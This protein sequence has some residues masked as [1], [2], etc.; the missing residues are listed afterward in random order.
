MSVSATGK[1]VAVIGGGPA[2][3]IAAETLA[4]AGASV[5]LYDRMPS[6]GRKFLM[7]GR[8]GLNLTHSEPLETFVRR[9]GTAAP[10]LSPLIEHFSPAGLTQWCEALGQ[11]TF[12]GSSGRVFPKSMKASPLLRAWLRRLATL[13]VTVETRT[14]WRGWSANGA[15]TFQRDTGEIF[16]V[17]P[18]ATI[19]A[20]GGASWPRLGADGGWVETLRATGVDVAPLVASNAGVAVAW[21]DHIRARFAGAP[22]KRIAITIDGATQRGEAVITAA[23]LEGGAIYALSPAIRA[24]LARGPAQISIDLRPDLTADVLAAR[25]ARPRGK[26]TLT[27]HLRKTLAL[28]PAAIAL[29]RDDTRGA[30][31]K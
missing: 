18:D 15:L 14:A 29:L 21:S 8:G 27:N 5:T 25:L 28:P 24:A 17:T 22:L 9:Y 12:V 23:G 19:L 13:G 30:L 7:A 20:L 11:P 4:T 16:N 26:D 3:L 10:V 2:G 31:T 1:T 6:L